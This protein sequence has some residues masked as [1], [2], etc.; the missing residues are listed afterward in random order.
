MSTKNNDWVAGAATAFLEFKR[1]IRGLNL[2]GSWA[3]TE[4]PELPRRGRVIYLDPSLTR[5][6]D[7]VVNASGAVVGRIQNTDPFYFSNHYV[8]VWA[9]VLTQ[10]P[11]D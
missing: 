8:S 6:T 5:C 2:R 4:V 9:L 7:T 11:G 1:I 10:C 3:C